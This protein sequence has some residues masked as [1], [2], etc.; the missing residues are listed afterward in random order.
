MHAYK[1]R[2]QVTFKVA[3]SHPFDLLAAI[4]RDCIGAITLYP[5]G[6]TLSNI[7]TIQASP[8]TAAEIENKLA[9]GCLL[10]LMVMVK[11]LVFSY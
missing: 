5:K 4:G 9:N 11:T 6:D 1:S 10:L 8:L 7:K 3:S 2:L